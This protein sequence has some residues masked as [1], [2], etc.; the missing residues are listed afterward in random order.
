MLDRSWSV[1]SVRTWVPTRRR[2]SCTDGCSIT[3]AT[4]WALLLHHP[5]ADDRRAYA[6]ARR[7]GEVPDGA[8]IGGLIEIHGEGGL[9]RDWTRGCVALTNPDMDDLFTHVD[10]GTPVTIV[11]SDEPGTLAA[12][13]GARAPAPEGGR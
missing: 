2:G 8:G 1:W 4:A 5:N 7:S 9:G 11:G 10:V 3:F 13:G 6:Q 12:I